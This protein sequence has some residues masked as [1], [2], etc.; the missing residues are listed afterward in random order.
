MLSLGRGEMVGLGMVERK[1]LGCQEWPRSILKEENSDE[2]IG[3][4]N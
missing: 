3:F 2:F 4:S 1:F